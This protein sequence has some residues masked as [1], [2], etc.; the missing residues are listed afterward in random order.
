MTSEQADLSF[1]EFKEDDIRSK[2]TK[3]YAK[4]R[5]ISTCE[6]L[7]LG[8]RASCLTLQSWDKL[9]SHAK[10]IKGL[11]KAATVLIEGH[12]SR[13]SYFDNPVT[14]NNRAINVRDALIF[15]GVDAGI[16]DIGVMAG[17]YGG[18]YGDSFYDEKV[19]FRIYL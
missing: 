19:E 2:N 17:Q 13:F 8:G 14:S 6:D 5:I 10:L 12:S 16:L 15:M 4:P 18:K 11:P 7:D 9:K 3:F 1:V